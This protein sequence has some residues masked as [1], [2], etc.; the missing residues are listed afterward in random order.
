MACKAI[1]FW[2]GLRLDAVS[3]NADNNQ[4]RLTG[5]YL[6][7][8]LFTSIY[9]GTLR[10]NSHGLLVFTN[11]LA[12][13]DKEGF[14]DIHPRAIAEEV[15]LTVEQVTAAIAVLEAPDDESRS[16]EEHGRRIVRKDAHR[17]WGWTVVNYTK[18]RAIRDEG[19]RREQNRRSQAAWRAKQAEAKQ[20]DNK[21][22]KPPSATV[23]HDNPISAHTEAYTEA[24]KY[25]EASPLVDSPPLATPQRTPCPTE[26]IISQ[27]HE[28]CPSLPRVSVLNDA[29]RKAIASRWRELMAEP[30]M[31][32]ADDQKAAGLE[33]WAW[34]FNDVSASDFLA[35]RATEWHATFDWLMKPTNFAKVVDGNYANQARRR[36]S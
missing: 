15:G 24:D 13:A 33:W 34:F 16:P 17:N 28:R 7:A 4:A 18:Y 6:Y 29:R 31:R 21:Q 8:K 32:K 9:Q 23:S 12:H 3:K 35:G 19:D 20:A 11:L 1:T 25:I 14:A 30:D 36:T 26:E 10:G 2:V 27:Y 5:V 22:S